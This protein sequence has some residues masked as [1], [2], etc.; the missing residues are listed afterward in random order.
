MNRKEISVEQVIEAL[1]TEATQIKGDKKRIVTH[2]AAIDNAK[3]KDALCFA[4]AT[5]SMSGSHKVDALAKIRKTK[6]GI[7]ITSNDIELHPDDYKEKTL[8]LVGN[9]RL[10]YI[11]VLRTLFEEG[12]S[13][14]I[15]PT[16]IIDP[17][18][19]IGPEVHIG[20]YTVVGK[21]T[22][23]AGS[24][25]HGH[26]YIYDNCFIGRNVEIYAGCL[27]GG[28]G[29]GFERNENGELEK[30]PQ[31]GGLVIEDDVEIQGLCNVEV[32]TIENTR[33]GKGTKI[34][35]YCHIGHNCKIGKHCVIAAD[36]MFGAGV[37]VEDFVWISPS[38]VLRNRVRIGEGSQVGT[39]A[40]VV[41]DVPPNELVMGFPA[42]PA[43][44][45][46]RILKKLKR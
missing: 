17:E 24:I 36:T 41:K 11:R 21:S 7:V 12:T 39:G 23:G 10:A 20:P 18:A 15:H 40:V 2:P 33:I 46:K 14:T 6:A 35:S 38:A 42:R 34:D 3:G 5:Q 27:L 4:G 43:E 19:D 30:F 9:P 32:G 31:L 45:F 22:I 25:I 8:I 16:A 1:Q 26:V 29:F 37:E 28:K 13:M 44:E